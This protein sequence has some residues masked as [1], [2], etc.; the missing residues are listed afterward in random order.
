MHRAEGL[1]AFAFFH[2]A[3]YRELQ[4]EFSPTATEMED[5]D[6]KPVSQVSALKPMLWTSLLSLPTVPGPDEAW[7][8]TLSKQDIGKGEAALPRAPFPSRLGL[9]HTSLTMMCCHTT[10]GL[11]LVSSHS[12]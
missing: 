7:E 8:S 6:G 2:K 12:I 4:W 3:V 11:G 5:E 1:H 9:G 10:E